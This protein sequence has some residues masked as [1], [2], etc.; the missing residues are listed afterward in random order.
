MIQSLQTPFLS[1]IILQAQTATGSA[2]ILVSRR[3]TDI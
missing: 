3:L 2:A 1:S